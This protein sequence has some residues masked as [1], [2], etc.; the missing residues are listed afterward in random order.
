MVHPIEDARGSGLWRFRV[1]VH[2]VNFRSI[3]MTHMSALKLVAEIFHVYRIH[4]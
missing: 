3:A 2:L 1:W 4:T